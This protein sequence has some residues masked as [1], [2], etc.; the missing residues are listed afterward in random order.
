[1]ALTKKDLEKLSEIFATKTDL[2]CLRQDLGKLSEI[3]ATKA[4]LQYL[5]RDL[6]DLKT[7][8]LDK[9]MKKLEDI[10]L[11]QKIAFS[12]YKRQEE[13][14]DNHETRIKKLETASV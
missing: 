8:Y 1:M 12:Q 14:I 10:S 2:Q 3:F 4:D 7:E 6:E 9:I 11:E 5:R 13:K